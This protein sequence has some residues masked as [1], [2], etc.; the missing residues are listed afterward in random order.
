MEERRLLLRMVSEIVASYVRNNSLSRD[1]VPPFIKSIYQELEA[2]AALEDKNRHKP[3]VPI[4]Q[5][6]RDD[7][8]ICLEDG[9]KFK[10]LK[11]HLRTTYDMTPEQYRRKWSLPP[12]YPMVAPNYAKKRSMVA[13][14]TGLGLR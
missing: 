4:E 2:L 13:H 10:M 14:K 8:L 7:Y 6:V 11:R 3:A 9:K 1:E 12:D 5:S